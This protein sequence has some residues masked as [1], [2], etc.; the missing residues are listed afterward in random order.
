MTKPQQP[1]LLATHTFC[2]QCSRLLPGAHV[3]HELQARGEDTEGKKYELQAR[4]A[5]SSHILSRMMFNVDNLSPDL[6]P[7]AEKKKLRML[8]H[9]L[10]LWPKLRLIRN[11]PFL[12]IH[13]LRLCKTL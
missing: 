9:F 8:E 5:A 3:G 4:L 10:E 7:I 11:R 2:L 6:I 12:N 1:A 13:T